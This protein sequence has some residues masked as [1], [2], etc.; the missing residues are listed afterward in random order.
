MFYPLYHIIEQENPR[1]FDSEG[2]QHYLS[3]NQEL[4]EFSNSFFGESDPAHCI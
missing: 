3:N 2:L 1:I 4:F